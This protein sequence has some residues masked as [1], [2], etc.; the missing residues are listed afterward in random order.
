MPSGLD[1][2]IDD[3]IALTDVEVAIALGDLAGCVFDVD[4]ELGDQLFVLV[5]ETFERLA[6]AA[7]RALL[8]HL[9]RDDSPDALLDAFAAQGRREAARSIRA[10]LAE[11][12]TDGRA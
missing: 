1:L 5:A 7:G 10:A 12:S 8:A 9:W 4:Q 3:A 6:P 2:T 11:A